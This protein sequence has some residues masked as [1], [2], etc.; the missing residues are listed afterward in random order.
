MIWACDLTEDAKRDLRSLPL[1]IKRRVARVLDQTALAPC[2]SSTG[3]RVARRI[4]P[5]HW[6]L[7]NIVR[8]HREAPDDHYCSHPAPL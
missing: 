2:E 7:S 4:P 3:R 5:A 6:L 8:P 1:E